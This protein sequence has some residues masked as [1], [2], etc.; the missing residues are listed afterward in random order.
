MKI[1]IISMLIILPLLAFI[2]CSPIGD[3]TNQKMETQIDKSQNEELLTLNNYQENIEDKSTNKSKSIAPKKEVYT[4]SEVDNIPLF[5]NCTQLQDPIKCS[6]KNI[7]KFIKDNIE[8]P[9]NNLDLE[10]S[11]K[12]YVTFIIHK[13]GS[14]SDVKYVHTDNLSCE[15]CQQAAVDVIGKMTEWTP[16]KKSNNPVDV[17]LTIPIR[18]RA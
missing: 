5:G 10:Q 9:K 15:G 16:G 2:S 12:E 7:T 11:G 3:K 4:L 17:Q 6:Q 13:D 18:F 8:Y 1:R 14:L